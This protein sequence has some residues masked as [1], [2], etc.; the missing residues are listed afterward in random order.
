MTRNRRN[1]NTDSPVVLGRVSGLYG[2]KGWVKLYS[3]TE[4]R[5]A[6]LGYRNCLIGRR[7]AWRPAEM[8][9]GRRQ[10]KT[11]IARLDDTADRDKAAELVGLDI[12]VARDALPETAEGEYYWADLE[13]LAV[14]HQD[15]RRLGRVAYLMATGA[16]D[17][18]VVQGDREI[19]IPFV[20]GEIVLDVDLA[21]GRIQV[22]WEWD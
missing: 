15:G 17:V 4:P 6:I 11:L 8:A 5:D 18:M 12:A 20:P 14:V 9:E 16:H 22:D 1:E 7:D 10:G 13:G 2:V 19:L 3:Y 21:S